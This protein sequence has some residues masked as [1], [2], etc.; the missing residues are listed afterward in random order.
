MEDRRGCCSPSS[1]PL[2][3]GDARPAG[4]QAGAATRGPVAARRGCAS[5]PVRA[6]AQR[7]A[8]GAA[9]CSA[10]CRSQRHSRGGGGVELGQRRLERGGGPRAR[11]EKTSFRSS[12]VSRHAVEN[13]GGCRR[14][15]CFDEAQ[16]RLRVGRFI[17]P[18]N[19]TTSIGWITTTTRYRC[20]PLTAY[21]SR[22]LPNAGKSV[23]SASARNAKRSLPRQP[24]PPLRRRARC[25]RAS[26]R[27]GSARSARVGAVGFSFATSPRERLVAPLGLGLLVHA[28]RE[29]LRPRSRPRA[30]ARAAARRALSSASR[31]HF[32]VLR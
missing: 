12:S 8:G 24:A 4:Q 28:A 9:S 5:R 6:G 3:T 18:T 23:P 21:V 16:F 26:A 20:G 10:I 29:R 2:P 25:S 19:A 15:G 27:N 11:G 22:R 13:L 30:A 14:F 32:A 1:S 7:R 31:V 17:S